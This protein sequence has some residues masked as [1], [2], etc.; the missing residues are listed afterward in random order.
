MYDIPIPENITYLFVKIGLII[1]V[2]SFWLAMT[3]RPVY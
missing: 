2:L 3:A 1:L